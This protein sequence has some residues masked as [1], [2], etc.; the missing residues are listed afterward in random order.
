[1]I[2][3]EKNKWKN[4]FKGSA[5]LQHLVVITE[6]LEREFPIC[7]VAG[8]QFGKPLI[9]TKGNPHLSGIPFLLGGN[10]LTQ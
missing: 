6:V 1:M 3:K 8:G 5:K 9:F 4:I 10:S 2:T 7:D